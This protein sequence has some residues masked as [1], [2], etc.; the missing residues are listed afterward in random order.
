MRNGLT[1]RG[2]YMV[3]QMATAQMLQTCVVERVQNATYDANTLVA[4]PGSR[5]Q[6]YPVPGQH[7]PLIGTCRI[8]EQENPSL[9][10]IGESEFT[11]YTTILSVPWNAPGG[12]NIAKHDEVQVVTDPSDPIRVGERY[13]IQS[14]KQGGQILATRSFILERLEPRP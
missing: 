2:T 10:Q 9:V 11:A 12:A 13:R 4:S 7:P 3:Q 14:F 6:I 1:A 8:W 5:T